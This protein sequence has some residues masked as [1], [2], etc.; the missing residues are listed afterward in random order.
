MIYTARPTQAGAILVFFGVYL[1]D[2]AP[3]SRDECNTRITTTLRRDV[4]TERETYIK[5]GRRMAA[6]LN[7]QIL[8]TS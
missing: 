8:P 7:H 5:V 3:S 6:V 2:P 1:L 4:G